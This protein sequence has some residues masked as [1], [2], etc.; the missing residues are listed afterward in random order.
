VAG[1]EKSGA[2]VLILGGPPWSEAMT[3]GEGGD[4]KPNKRNEE[5]GRRDRAQNHV[6]LRNVGGRKDGSGSMPPTTVTFFS[7]FFFNHMHLFKIQRPP[8]S[9]PSIFL[10]L[11]I[12]T[13]FG[14]HKPQG[15]VFISSQYIYFGFSLG[16]HFS[17][18]IYISPLL[19]GFLF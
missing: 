11:K 18:E 1:R 10:P 16:L 15:L 14:Q 9:A 13:A 2:G 5:Y 3:K 7:F 8:R 12:L 6:V 4:A 19:R 17:S